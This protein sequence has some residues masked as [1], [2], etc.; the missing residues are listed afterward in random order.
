M[1]S[2]SENKVEE[3]TVWHLYPNSNISHSHLQLKKLNM[4]HLLQE[5]KEFYNER[6]IASSYPLRSGTKCVFKNPRTK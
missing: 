3:K 4:D 6:L 5:T 1:S 2:P